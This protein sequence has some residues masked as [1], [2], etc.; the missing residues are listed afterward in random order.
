MTPQAVRYIDRR[1]PGRTLIVL[2]L[3]AKPD[4]PSARL[5]SVSGSR[6]ARPDLPTILHRDARTRNRLRPPSRLEAA[7]DRLTDCKARFGTDPVGPGEAS[8]VALGTSL[9]HLA[10]KRLAPA[11]L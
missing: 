6:R 7:S 5:L 1:P 4:G 11:S 3:S 10:L 9:E 8:L 2:D